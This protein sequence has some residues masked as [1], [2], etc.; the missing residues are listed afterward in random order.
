MTTSLTNASVTL[1]DTGE[2]AGNNIWLDR[3]NS[4]FTYFDGQ[5][6]T[7]STAKAYGDSEQSRMKLKDTSETVYSLGNISGAVAVDYTNGH[8]QHGVVTG[9]ITGITISN[10]PASGNAG[11][12]TLELTQDGT[13]GR[14]LTLASAY[15]TPGGAGITLSTGANDVDTLHLFTRDGGTNIRVTANL[16]WS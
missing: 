16:N 15:K 9:N 7:T 6:T 2:T 1:F 8:Y 10:W 11:W 14:T 5:I 12:L 3:V 13:G 4:A